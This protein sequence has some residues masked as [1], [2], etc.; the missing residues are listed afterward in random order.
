[1]SGQQ[2]TLEGVVTATNMW[3]EKY[4]ISEPQGGAWRGLFIFDIDTMP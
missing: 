2:V 3:S 1:M 4:F